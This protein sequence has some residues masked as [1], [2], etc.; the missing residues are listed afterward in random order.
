MLINKTSATTSE[1]VMSAQK[2]CG[3]GGRHNNRGRE[4]SNLSGRASSSSY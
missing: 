1:V 2:N 3:G 4:Y